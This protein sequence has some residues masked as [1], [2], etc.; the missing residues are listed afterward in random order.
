MQ[1][2]FAGTNPN[3]E[4]RIPIK[5]MMTLLTAAMTQP[6][7]NFFPTSTVETTVNTHDM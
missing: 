6:C 2:R 5:Q 3:C 7:H 4:V 1:N